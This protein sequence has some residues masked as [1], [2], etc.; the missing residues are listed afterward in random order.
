[1]QYMGQKLRHEL[2]Y[3]INLSTYYELRGHIKYFMQKDENTIN[4]DGYLISSLYFDDVFQSALEEKINGT[5]FR[6]K[7][8]IRVYEKGDQLINLECKIKYDS[9]I[10]KVSARLTREQYDKILRGDYEFLADRPEIICKEVYALNRTRLLKPVTVVEYTREAY[11]APQG[12][13]RV[14]FD[15]NISASVFG[16][17]MF[18]SELVL[19]GILPEN[20]MVLEVKYDDFI[21]T[22][23]LNLLQTN[24]A[25]K[26]A[27]SKYVMCRN[28][29]LRVRHYD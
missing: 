10:S 25:R 27:I 5:R 8:R 24:Q 18:D 3:Y 6:K 11:V 19:A 12:N 2:K 1:M 9:F 26:C 22:F 4:E 13:V 17:D 7:Y 29:N 15:K 28:K 23:I 14:T 21:P 20:I 16:I